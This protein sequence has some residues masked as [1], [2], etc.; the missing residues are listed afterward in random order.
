MSRFFI[1]ANIPMYAA[2][3]EHPHKQPSIKLLIDIAAGKIF[4]VTSSEVLQ[5]ILYRYYAIGNLRAGLEIFD[6]FSKAVEQVLPITFAVIKE[7]RLLLGKYAKLNISPRDAL[8]IA[9]S[10]QNKLDIVTYDKDF[11]RFSIMGVKKVLPEELIL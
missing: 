6:R 4:G 7:S 9:V 5:E 3:K 1:D 2:G 8:H 11:D 10:R